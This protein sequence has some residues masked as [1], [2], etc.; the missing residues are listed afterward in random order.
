MKNIENIII[1]CTN[2][3]FISDVHLGVR[4]SSEEWQENIKSYFYNWF[5]PYI[6]DYLKK[7]PNSIIIGLGDIYDDRK[8]IDI[9]VNEL[10]LD[11]FE[12]LGKIIPTYIINGNHDLSKKTNKGNSSLRNLEY[13]PGITIIKEPT[14]LKIKYNNKQISK[15]IAI[16]YLGD[17]AEENKRLLE[18]SGKSDY[19]L[20]HTD[21]SKM[22]LDNGMSFLV[23]E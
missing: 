21:I 22:K 11:I 2:I 20:M 1:Q 16:P 5:I 9:N 23:I 4:S 12:D 7:F 13:V 14:L 6:K 10:T 19:A 8:A 3:I 15:I 18:F 17:H